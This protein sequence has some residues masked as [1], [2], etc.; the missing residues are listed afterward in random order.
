MR[1]RSNAWLFYLGMTMVTPA[2]LEPHRKGSSGENYWF[3]L[4]SGTVII[5]TDN[6]PSSSI[7]L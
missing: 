3:F 7:K 2:P 1:A 4:K 5:R 6:A